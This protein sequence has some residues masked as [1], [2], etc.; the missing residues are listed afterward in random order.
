MVPPPLSGDSL[1]SGV[2]NLGIEDPG[3]GSGPAIPPQRPVKPSSSWV[4]PAQWIV[5][6]DGTA[7]STRPPTR[8][9]DDCVDGAVPIDI[10]RSIQAGPCP[11]ARRTT[12]SLVWRLTKGF[13]LKWSM[14]APCTQTNDHSSCV[15]TSNS[16]TASEISTAVGHGLLNGTS[17]QT[18]TALSTRPPIRAVDDCA[19][20]ADIPERID[21]PLEQAVPCCSLTCGRNRSSGGSPR[22]CRPGA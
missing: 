2:I 16:S 6:A 17:L 19:D 10:E 5:R 11:G 15:Q 9:V 12:D 4:Q 13:V 1:A 3:A 22:G 18:G 21:G 8:A 7:S 20:R 14:V